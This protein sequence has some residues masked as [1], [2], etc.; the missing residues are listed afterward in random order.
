MRKHDLVIVG[1][2]LAS[3]RCATGLR[4]AGFDGRIT[5]VGSESEL[6]Y[7]RPALS[8]EFLVGS[9]RADDLY[10]TSMKKLNDASIDVVLN[11]KVEQVS[12]GEIW[13][14][15]GDESKD[16][17][18]VEWD[19]LVI[20]TGVRPRTS[21]LFAGAGNVVYLRTLTD[22]YRLKS[23]MSQHSSA[24]VTII[25][26]GFIGSEVA[27]SAIG[28]G[29]Q[30]TMIESAEIPFA[31]T[32]GIE[33]GSVLAGHYQSCGVDLHTGD[34]VVGVD[35]DHHGDA[36]RIRTSSGRSIETDLIVVG[37]GTI[38]NDELVGGSG[39]GIPVNQ[40]GQTRHEG[41]YAIGDVSLNF[42]S[43][44]NVWRRNEHWCH[45][46]V[47]ARRV[48]NKIA[49]GTQ[50]L[51]Q[52]VSYVWSDQFDLRLQLAGS[53]LQPEGSVTVHDAEASSLLVEYRNAS[54]DVV[55]VLGINRPR[56]ISS[57]R[58]DQS[59]RP[60]HAAFAKAG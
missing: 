46:D 18:Q 19:T 58:R 56:E 32:L 11:T 50:V 55:G 54:G 53:G 36:C 15:R 45:A 12:A 13:L 20:A 3:L 21:P 17:R 9:R 43:G 14:L 51:P 48:A 59:A 7:E 30:V 27:S 42:D 41:V 35:V 47:Q 4:S 23:L 25:G 1:F 37:I 24:R 8:K 34:Q 16:R 2:G 10:L 5:I 28:M 40:F 52:P 29:H 60:D 22:A 26:C 57:W 44:T 39:A 49:G 33:A 31:N 38:G 6:P